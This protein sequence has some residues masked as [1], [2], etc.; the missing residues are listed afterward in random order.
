MLMNIRNI[1]L[2]LTL[3]SLAAACS[4]MKNRE[5]D[6]QVLARYMDNAGEPIE[7]F[8]YLG[9][10]DGWRALGRDK[11]VVWTGI[12][13]AY[14]LTVQTPCTNLPFANAVGL[15][16]TTGT[17]SRGFDSVKVGRGE[18]CRINEIRKVDYKKVREIERAGG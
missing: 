12:N 13:D 1:L 11:L 3:A 10:F 17:V 7:H 18:E 2:T 9:R 6:E 4:H 8:S 5:S 14:L 15:T 16:T